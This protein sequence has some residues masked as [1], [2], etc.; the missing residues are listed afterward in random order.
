MKASVY[1][2]ALSLCF[3]LANGVL[4]VNPGNPHNFPTIQSAIDAVPSD[5]SQWIEISIKEGIYN[6]KVT[7]PSDKPFIY[8]KGD[9]VGKTTVTWGDNGT[10]ETSP[11]IS[12]LADN[13]LVSGIKFVNSFNYPPKN[14]N[15]SWAVAARIAG[16][17]LAFY[18]CSFLGFQD[19]LYDERGRHYFNQC[20]IEGAVDFIFGNGQ[21][22]Y[23]QCRIL[24]NTPE[25][26]YI[27]A[28]GRYDPNDS[29]GF[30]FKKCRV[31]R[32]S[33]GKTYLGRAWKEYSRVIFYKSLMANN[34]LPE[35]WDSWD[36]DVKNLTF[37]E[38]HCYG[39]GYDTS[40]RV[41]WVKTLR[42]NELMAFVDI[43]YIDSERWIGQQPTV[44]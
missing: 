9:G 14:N 22:I 43:S 3:T 37:V 13:T 10:I 28:H 25:I 29:S 15:P 17:K 44:H 31:I 21:S 35:G 5:N 26:G 6:E 34:I 42:P 11:T 7:I 12:F 33:E 8:L 18:Q 4:Y 1:I 32:K 38:H 2:L 19:T 39:P 27:A 36:K 23:E 16:D 20:T 30:V 41:N 40:K 24:L